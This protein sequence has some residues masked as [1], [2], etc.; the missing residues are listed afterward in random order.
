MSPPWQHRAWFVYLKPKDSCASINRILTKQ[1]G[2]KIK[3]R[4]DYRI[5]GYLG[6]LLFKRTVQEGGGRAHC[7]NRYQEPSF[8]SPK[9]TF[10]KHDI[11]QSF[12]DIF[13]NNKIDTAIHLAFVV[14]PIHNETAAHRIN[15]EG[16][17]NFLEACRKAN[18]A[19]IYYIGQSYR[20]GASVYNPMLFTENMPLNP[21]LG[22]PL[23]V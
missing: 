14:A 15:I 7:R 23:C 4:S 1:K 18:V 12:V 17:K 8:K 10:I 16:S 20:L 11:R 9:F 6:T 3:N 21:N 19:Q 2:S 5:S 22:F 13:T